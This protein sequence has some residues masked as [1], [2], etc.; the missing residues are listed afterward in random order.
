MKTQSA[1]VCVT[2]FISIFVQTCCAFLLQDTSHEAVVSLGMAV[3]FGQSFE[4]VRKPSPLPYA[5]T[6]WP[7]GGCPCS[8]EPV[9]FCFNGFLFYRMLISDSS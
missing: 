6:I 5:M 1:T 2:A 9:K 7:Q 3:R 4:V 8:L